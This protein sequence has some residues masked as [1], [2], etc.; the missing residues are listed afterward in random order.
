M[1]AT[2]RIALSLFLLLAAGAV[3]TPIPFIRGLTIV[4]VLHTPEG[5]RENVMTVGD[6]SPAGVTYTWQYRERKNGSRPTDER[7]ERFVRASDM[8][9]APRL[10]PVFQRGAGREEAPG[11]T[12]LSLSRASYNRLRVERSIPYTVVRIDSSPSSQAF[13][14]L[15]SRV[16]FKGTLSLVSAEPELMPML[17]NARRTSVAALH[18]KA[19]FVYQTQKDDSDYWVLADSTHP[20]ILKVV[21]GPRV[22]QTIRLD[23]PES[24]SVSA[25]SVERE[26]E[27]ECRA[28]LPGIYFAFA[29]AEL[30]P[31]SDPELANIAAVLARHPSWSFSIE[32]HTDSIGGAASNTALSRAR[33]EAVRR[34]LVDERGIAAARVQASGFGATRPRETNATLEGR[35]RNRRVEI[36]RNC[37][38]Q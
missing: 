20:L 37:V 12:A 36:V 29:S 23:F 25:Q 19:D 32:G 13:G 4:S 22:Y 5:D 11:Y 18:L 24:T 30:Q 21:K 14:S 8:A 1:F 17:V 27:H 7:F 31:A 33:A 3:R 38:R 16:P 15:A 34:A 10:N 2:S 9:A 35:A 26:L 28:E 6:I